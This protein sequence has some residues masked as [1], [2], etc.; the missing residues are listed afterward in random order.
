[1]SG[2]LSALYSLCTTRQAMSGLTSWVS[3][4]ACCCHAAQQQSLFKSNIKAAGGAAPFRSSSV[5]SPHPSC[6][7][8]NC[9]R[10]QKLP[11]MQLRVRSSCELGAICPLH[12]CP[13]SHTASS[14]SAIH[15]MP[16]LS[17]VAYTVCVVYM[18]VSSCSWAWHTT[19]TTTRPRPLQ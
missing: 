3:S 2:T 6:A 16:L 8:M 17:H 9:Q 13:Q 15:N 7:A 11:C 14:S 19:S 1:M 10:V 5:A 4:P 18:Q 12:H